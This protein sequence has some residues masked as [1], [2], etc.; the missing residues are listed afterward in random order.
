MLLATHSRRPMPSG[1]GAAGR[2]A[3]RCRRRRGFGLGGQR[4]PGRRSA[5][6]RRRS[7]RR[8]A[9]IRSARIQSIMPGSSPARPASRGSGP[10]P[11][12]SSASASSGAPSGSSHHGKLTHPPASRT[13]SWPAAA[14]TPRAAA[15]RDHP[16]EPRGGHLAQR[17]GDRPERPQA[18]G[19]CRR[20]ALDRRRHPARVGRLDPEHLEPAVA[21]RGARQRRIEPARR[22]SH[23]PSP[24]RAHH[25]SPGPKS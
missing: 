22:R 23:A 18:V 16:V 8:N 1:G 21:A 4:R 14:S 20:S 10:R 13:I 3:G 7:R 15:Q 5:A 11:P 6:A 9:A 17:R 24:R 25:S 2:A 19:G 12:A